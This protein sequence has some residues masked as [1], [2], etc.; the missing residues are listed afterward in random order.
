ML[1]NTVIPL[2]LLITP[3]AAPNR[4]WLLLSFFCFLAWSGLIWWD[5]DRAVA[6]CRK[7][8][9]DAC[10][11]AGWDMMIWIAW[12]ILYSF[13]FLFRLLLEAAQLLSKLRQNGD[14]P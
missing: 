7:T 9:E 14:N 6:H 10:D 1:W 3:I 4:K 2:L 11:W 8:G 12:A 5:L 13:I